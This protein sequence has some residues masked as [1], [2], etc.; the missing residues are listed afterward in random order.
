[1][2]RFYYIKRSIYRDHV[3]E[4]AI[5]HRHGKRQE[6]RLPLIAICDHSLNPMDIGAKAPQ[7]HLL[8]FPCL[9]SQRVCIYPFVHRHV[10]RLG[11]I[12]QYIEHGGLINDREKCDCGNYLFEDISNL[13]LDF[14]FGFGWRSVLGWIVYVGLHEI[15]MNVR[16]R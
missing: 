14:R 12:C 2:P 6:V 13:G 9:N 1:V 16:F 5:G 8:T 4:P 7:L 3:L 11:G 10:C 15:G